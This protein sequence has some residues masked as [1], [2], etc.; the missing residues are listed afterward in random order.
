MLP[1]PPG[2]R[3]TLGI[4]GAKSRPGLAVPD[5]VHHVKLAS[6]CK[7]P[8]RRT[9]T[10]ATASLGSTST[11]SAV[12]STRIGP[13]LPARADVSPEGRA[14]V[15][16]APGL[17]AG[18]GGATAA[19]VAGGAVAVGAAAVGAAAVGVAAVG[20]VAVG[21]VVFGAAVAGAMADRASG[22]VGACVVA[23]PVGAAALAPPALE[24]VPLREVT[25]GSEV[26]AA[27]DTGVD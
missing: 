14:Y 18:V 24:A 13:A 21:I 23:A 8:L 25:S 2:M 19:A 27:W 22:V 17:D 3:S 26:G 11:V 7:S 1:L 16:A 5:S 12:I 10:R 6:P 20:I 4:T 9:V 15:V